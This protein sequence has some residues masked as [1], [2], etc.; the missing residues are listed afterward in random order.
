[1]ATKLL[2]ALRPPAGL[3]AAAAE[4][5]PTLYLGPRAITY[6]L[7]RGGRLT[8]GLS[9][10]CLAEDG[11]NR[12]DGGGGAGANIGDGG[13]GGKDGDGIVGNGKKGI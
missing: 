9:S 5:S 3:A 11:N 8:S 7:F 2:F 13:N 1:M 12:G 4:L 10:L 6:S